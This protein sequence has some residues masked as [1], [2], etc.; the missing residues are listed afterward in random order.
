[1]PFNGE[2]LHDLLGPVNQ[3]RSIADLILKKHRGTMDP[4]T[5]VLFAYMQNSADRLQ[6]LLAG[7]RK[8]TSVLNDRG[9][10]TTCDGNAILAGALI[11]LQPVIEETGARVTYDH[12]PNLHC[13]PA[14]LC[15]VFSSLIENSIKFRSESRPE[16]HFTAF[17]ERDSWVISVQDNGIGIDPRNR[18]RIFSVFKRI[19]NDEYPGAG[20][21]LAIVRHILEHHG[22]R[23]WVD[24]SLGHGATFFVVL[25][26]R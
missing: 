1:V 13:N 4:E 26:S 23:V 19:H 9:Q 3:I 16:I 21:G 20:V 12:L 17:P 6:N 2:A 15:F 14:Q 5:E 10:K 22:G 24:S 7:L 25:P 11:E 8:Y 18:E